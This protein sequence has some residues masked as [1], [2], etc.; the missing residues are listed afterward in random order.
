MPIAAT[1]R[2]ALSWLELPLASDGR[3]A[4][5]LFLAPSSPLAPC[6]VLYGGAL[7]CLRPMPWDLGYP[8]VLSAVF[9]QEPIGRLKV[10]RH[11]G[12]PLQVATGI[13]MI[14]FGVVMA[15]G[16]L[17]AV[18]YLATRRLSGARTNRLTPT[19]PSSAQQAS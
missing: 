15:T 9:M 1:T 16:Q 18:A 5:D 2:R 14:V 4:S 7:G 19:E 6:K 13:I 17:T 11:A 10:L 3:H 8:F 12:R